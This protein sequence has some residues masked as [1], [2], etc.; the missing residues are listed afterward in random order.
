M[1][2]KTTVHKFV[3]Q[4]GYELVEKFGKFETSKMLKISRPTIDAILKKFPTKP[5]KTLPKYVFQWEETAGNQLFIEKYQGKIRQFR[6][7]VVQGMKAWLLLGK[8]DPVSWD[9]DDFRKIWKAEEFRDSTTGKMSYEYACMF[10]KWIVGIGKGQFC[11]LEE[12]ETKGLKRPKGMKKQWFLE[13]NEIIRLIETM[14]K[15]DLLVSFTVALLS[16][17]RASSVMKSDVSKG[18]R[19]MDI[20]EQNYG[21]LMFEPKRKKYV[22]RLFHSKVIELLKRYIITYGIKPNEPLFLH[23]QVMR[24]RLKE[25]ALKAGVSKIAGMRGAWHI[26][27]HT[28]VSQGAY[29]GLSMEV[30]IEQAGTDAQT[31][32]DYYAGIKQKKMRVELLGEKVEIEPFHLWA[33]RVIIEPAI[34]KYQELRMVEP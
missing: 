2:K 12:F 8:K 3:T 6:D 21:I 27:K 34:R 14:D 33:L 13:D 28:F 18:I 20:D 4:Q 30:I 5:D 22:L 16:G 24:N 23:Y 10:R 29:H 11:S 7:Y 15:P 9:V 31:L 19:P 26:T 1:I 32:L 25:V 17:G